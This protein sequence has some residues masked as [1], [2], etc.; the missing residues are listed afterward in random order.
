M[1]STRE[2]FTNSVGGRF[3]SCKATRPRNRALQL[4][5]LR[6]EERKDNLPEISSLSTRADYVDDDIMK[7]D[8]E[9]SNNRPVIPMRKAK[10]EAQGR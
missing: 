8:G 4:L 1:Q 3:Y 9:T 10:P 5:L 2:R 6:L 7:D